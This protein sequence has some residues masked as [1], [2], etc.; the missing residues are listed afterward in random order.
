MNC[1]RQG[2]RIL[3]GFFKAIKCYLLS[4]LLLQTKVLMRFMQI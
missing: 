2:L 1:L 3:Y 4:V